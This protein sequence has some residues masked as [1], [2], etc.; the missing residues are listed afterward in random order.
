MAYTKRDSQRK[1]LRADS[2]LGGHGLLAGLRTHMR[3]P[4]VPPSESNG[5]Q[6]IAHLPRICFPGMEVI[7][8]WFRVYVKMK[9]PQ[10]NHS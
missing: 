9:V 6:P 4:T 10:D 1:Q 8:L 2:I 5:K 7:I 3:V